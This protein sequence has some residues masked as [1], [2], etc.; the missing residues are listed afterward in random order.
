MIFTFLI[1]SLF[2]LL[3]GVVTLILTPINILITNYLPSVDTALGSVNSLLSMLADSF[4]YAVSWTLLSPLALQLIVLYFTF[5]LV[6]PL[7]LYFIK[8]IVKWIS[9]IK[10]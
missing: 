6:F 7:S 10:P 9:K 3:I 8:L 2:Q 5:V 4:K 1:I